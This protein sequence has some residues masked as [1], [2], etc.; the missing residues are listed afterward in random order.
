[1]LSKISMKEEMMNGGQ[2]L[3]QAA[4]S[5]KDNGRKK[6]QSPSAAKPHPKRVIRGKAGTVRG[7]IVRGMIC[8]PFFSFP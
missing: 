8:K 2:G 3:P 1:M 4:E 5:N 6:A 7:I